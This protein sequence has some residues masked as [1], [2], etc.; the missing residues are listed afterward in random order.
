M[1]SK[2]AVGMA[3]SVDP[4]Q[5][6]DLGLHCLYRPVYPKLRIITVIQ[7]GK[8]NA[9]RLAEFLPC[10]FIS[11]LEPKANLYIAELL[12]YLCLS[13]HHQHFLITSRSFDANFDKTL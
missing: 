9:C 7:F 3:N 8:V 5:T 11:F 2:D 13:I 6:S 10:M 1:C 12:W 4:D